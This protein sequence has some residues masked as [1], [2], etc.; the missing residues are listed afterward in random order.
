MIAHDIFQ[1][2]PF[3]ISVSIKVWFKLSKCRLGF[4]FWK[5]R[6]KG[7]IKT[8]SG[9]VSGCLAM[10]KIQWAEVKVVTAVFCSFA[11]SGGELSQRWS[12][13][14]PCRR[15][16]GVLQGRHMNILAIV[17]GWSVCVFLKVQGLFLA[18]LQQLERIL[19][20]SAKIISKLHGCTT[21]VSHR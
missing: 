11:V 9:L 12:T 15:G 2:I 19:H 20:Q 5:W 8:L 1:R 3:F 13:L 17:C 7:R 14:R 21:H 18:A 4:V 6:G 16:Q 10:V